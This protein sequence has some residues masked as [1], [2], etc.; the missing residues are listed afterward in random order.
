[1]KRKIL[2]LLLAAACVI[3]AA[4]CKADNTDE[5]PPAQTPGGDVNDQTPSGGGSQEQKDVIYASGTALT[6]VYAQKEIPVVEATKIFD[7]LTSKGVDVMTADPS[8]EKQPHEIVFGPTDRDVSKMAYTQLGR[9]EREEDF[10]GYC[11]YSDG[12]SIAVAYDEAYLGFEVARDEA[13]VQ[14][15]AVIAPEALT[16]KKGVIKSE[17][18]N[19]IEYQQAIDDARIDADWIELEA[20]LAKK[21]GAETAKAMTDALKSYY[22]MYLDDLV[23][24]FANLYDPAVGGFYFSNSGRNSEGYLPDLESTYQTLGFLTSSGITSDLN[25]FLSDRIKGELVAFVKGLQDPTNGYFYHP[26]WGKA[27]T[28]K[29]PARLGRDLGHATNLLKIFGQKPTYDAPNGVAGEMPLGAAPASFLTGRLSSSSASAVSKVVLVA[30]EESGVPSHLLNEENF[31]KYLASYDAKIKD[32]AYWVGNEFESQATQ[33]VNRDKV[34]AARGETYSLCQIAADW[35]TSHQD[36]ETGL[37]EPYEGNEYD[38]VNGI[39]KISS[40]YNKMGKPVPQAEKLLDYAIVAITADFDPHHVCCV[41][42]TWYAITVLTEN[43]AAYYE[44]ADAII[45]KVEKTCVENYPEMVIATRNKFSLFMK[46]DGASK[47]GFS[48]FQNK[49]SNTSQGLPVA[50]DNVNEADVNSSYICSSG[51]TW[52]LFNIIGEDMIDMYTATDGMR[53]NKIINDLGDVIKDKEIEAVPVDFDEMTIETLKEQGVIDYWIPEGNGKLVVEKGNPY[54]NES[55]VLHLNV[56]GKNTLFQF[57]LSKP[58]GTYNAVAFETEV[59]FAPEQTCTYELLFFGNPSSVRHVNI[60]VKAVPDD[61]VYVYS[62]DFEEIK[63]AECG[64]WFNLRV[65]YGKLNSTTIKSDVIVNGRLKATASTPYSGEGLGADTCKRI[66]FSA[67][68][69]ASSVGDVYFDDTFLEQFIKDLPVIPDEDMGPD[70][71]ETGILTYDKKLIGA[72]YNSGLLDS[73]LVSGTLTIVD[74]T[75]YGE[76]SRILQLATVNGS[77]DVLQVMTTK[78]FDGANALRFE[79]DMMID[80]RS[81][82]SYDVLIFGSSSNKA[83]SMVIYADES[84]V[85]LSSYDL[86]KTKVAEAGEWFKFSITYTKISNSKVCAEICVNG[87]RVSIDTTPYDPDKVPSNKDVYRVQFNSW[88]ATVGSLNLDNT[89]LMQVVYEVPELPGPVGPTLPD[90]VPESPFEGGNVGDDDWT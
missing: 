72:Y 58:Q 31:R 63:I 9:M 69:A 52:H 15:G 8:S 78:S 80:A 65:D 35:F 59:M 18:F 11:I 30:G 7:A 2:A 82:S 45:E 53:F 71:A 28:D 57:N 66:Q 25:S 43:V 24:W 1:M 3:T 22:S 79:T 84:G 17:L 70:E 77:N 27:L 23:D 49:T 46:T 41:L 38:C 42:N 89:S 64:E 88:S 86:A 33:I 39:L 44:N 20:N 90:P 12:S 73:G 14:L 81:A 21:H 75:P 4:S 61:G 26:Q 48:Y 85:Y 5:E 68:H 36:P 34:L 87:T 62:G 51:V 74:G 56:T 76:S 55:D 83:H 60:M 29:Y 13:L 47:G 6:L 10:V 16:A 50:L 67:Y 54:G 40:A 32:D 37:W 19:A